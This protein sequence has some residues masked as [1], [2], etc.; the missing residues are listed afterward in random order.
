MITNEKRIR[1]KRAAELIILQH[2]GIL[3]EMADEF[4]RKLSVLFVS[5]DRKKANSLT[6]VR[7]RWLKVK[8]DTV[9]EY[10]VEQEEV[11]ELHN[12][13]HVEVDELREWLEATTVASRSTPSP[14]VHEP[15]EVQVDADWTRLA[16]D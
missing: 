14:S 15:G 2:L 3:G 5:S 8:D 11:K 1:T 13:H 10:C 4:E 9:T 6:R 16:L 7:K 12:L